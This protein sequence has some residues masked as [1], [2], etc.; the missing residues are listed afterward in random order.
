MYQRI[1]TAST[2]MMVALCLLFVNKA[3]SQVTTAD[4][5]GTVTDQAG[6][7]V[8]N[9]KITVTNTATNDTKTVT[10]TG[11]GDFV[12]NLLPSGQ[13]TVT[14]EAPSFKK[15]TANTSVVSG[16]RQRVDIKLQVGNVTEVVEVAATA[17]AL[18]TDSATLSTVV[19]AQS[20]QDLPLNGRNFVTLVQSTV[21]VAP[22]PAN[23]ILS[24]TRP[25]DR[26][27]TGNISANGQNEIF[28][29]NLVDG[30]DNND[31]E[32]FLIMLRPSI[33]M[34]IGRAHV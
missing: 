17:P 31:R 14:A 8:P 19:G 5:L 12:V 22:G 18:Q 25:D 30:M 7:V 29:N 28:N 2:V 9:V 34:K 6:A 26:R 16:D 10:T 13:Y 24:G 21:G 15:A 20:V 27:Q 32:H 1:V 33:D 3:S 23:S 11:S 4:I